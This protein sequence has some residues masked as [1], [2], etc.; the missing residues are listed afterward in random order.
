MGQWRP[1]V[2][3]I[4]HPFPIS[5]AALIVAKQ[6]DIPVVATNH[7]IPSCTLFGLKETQLYRPVEWLF[8]T[9]IN[10][11]LK[12]C[13]TVTTPT[14]TAAGMLR[15]IGFSGPI[16]AVSNGVDTHCFQPSDVNDYSRA[17]I[18]IVLYTGR[19]DDDKNT[20]TII[21]A[22]PHVL[23]RTKA[24]FRIGGE[25]TDRARL[26]QKVTALNLSHV[27]SFT[28]Y[29]SDSEL[30][31]VYKNADVYVIASTVELQSLSTLDAM[32][33]GL[34]V[35]A[36]DAGALPELVKSGMNGYVVSPGDS[37]AFGNAVAEVLLNRDRRRA[38]G[39][40]SRLIAESHSLAK[41]VSQYEEILHQATLKAQ[42]GVIH[43]SAST[44]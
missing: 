2:V 27:V 10:A 26:Q 28:G 19:L 25:G 30:P 37:E 17:E 24:R 11:F 13:V 44:G 22:I 35:V 40:H 5:S 6:Y 39:E 9:Y 41:M 23:K 16:E 32:A 7:T 21:D 15:E 33:S 1:D 14:R 31:Q 8:S 34:P 38:M 29:V 4:H 20:D 36:V 3:H 42:S 18:P 43:G 12:Q